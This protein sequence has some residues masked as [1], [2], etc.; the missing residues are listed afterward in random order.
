VHHELREVKALVVAKAT[1]E[2]AAAF[3]TWLVA[4]AQA[5]ADAAKEGGL[6]GFKAELVSDGEHARP[7]S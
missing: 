7:D 2:E 4:S 6:M 5:S 1:P 3:G